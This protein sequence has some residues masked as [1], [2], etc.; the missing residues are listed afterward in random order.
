[1]YIAINRFKVNSEDENTFVDIW[2]NWNKHLHEVAGFIRFHL[3][4]GSSQQGFTLFSSLTKWASE[5]AFVDWT[6]S[7]AF[8]S[9]HAHAGKNPRDLYL[10]P[11]E[12]ECY[13]VVL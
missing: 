1:M 5:Q 9:V 8:K 13:E 4:R 10:A 12:L 2:R 6:H 3:L 11:S 7:Q